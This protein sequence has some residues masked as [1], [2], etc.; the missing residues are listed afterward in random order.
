MRRVS[1]RCCMRMQSPKV[2]EPSAARTN[3]C[4]HGSEQKTLGYRTVLLCGSRCAPHRE[5]NPDIGALDSA[6]ASVM[7]SS[8]SIAVAELARDFPNHNLSVSTLFELT[9]SLG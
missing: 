6:P 7:P 4:S 1:S 8:I 5:H 9:S 2:R 3:S